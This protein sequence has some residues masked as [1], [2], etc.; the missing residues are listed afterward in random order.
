VIV[1]KFDMEVRWTLRQLRALPFKSTTKGLQVVA[2]H[3]LLDKLEKRQSTSGG[4]NL[5]RY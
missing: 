1:G 3:G 4:C 2:G 5:G